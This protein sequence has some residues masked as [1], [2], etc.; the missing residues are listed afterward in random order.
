MPCKDSIV[1]EIKL[2]KMSML[3]TAGYGVRLTLR[4]V[5]EVSSM[6]RGSI[7]AS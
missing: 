2:F 5:S 6:S 3:N 1:T 4:S 7:P